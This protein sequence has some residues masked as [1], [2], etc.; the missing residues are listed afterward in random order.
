[1]RQH[2]QIVPATSHGQLVGIEEAFQAFPPLDSPEYI[3]HI[4]SIPSNMLP[5]E[6]LVRAF[7][8]LPTDGDG[9]RATL[10][11]LFGKS[12]T[13]WNYLGPLVA[14]ARRRADLDDYEDLLQDALRR[15]FKVLST[16]RGAYAEKFWHS[17]CRRE[18]SDAWR[19][20]YGRR[21]E[22]LPPEKP[23]EYDED[24]EA[25]DLSALASVV[26]PWHSTIESNQA[27]RI[28]QIARCVVDE[29]GDEFIRAVAHAAWFA[30]ERPPVSGVGGRGEN[31]PPLTSTFKNKSRHQ[32]TR[33]LRHADTQLLAALQNTKDLMW[34][35]GLAALLEGLRKGDSGIR[36]SRRKR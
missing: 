20:R 15:I 2:A 35:D 32:I 10:E 9:A 5:P 6:A 14:Y 26:P 33:A 3:R 8:Q 1:M 4:Q 21:G 31:T 30:N 25:K 34:T 13:R 17:Y 7:R 18:L 22:R 19:E 36:P 12:G 24:G 11:C 16:P 29:I 28:E 23:L 27:H